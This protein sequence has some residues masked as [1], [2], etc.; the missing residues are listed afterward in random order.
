MLQATCQVKTKDDPP[1][2]RML[3]EP[4]P[5][6]IYLPLVEESGRIFP[7]A[8]P[9]STFNIQH[10]T[11]NIRHST[12]DIRYSI[13]PSFLHPTQKTPAAFATGVPI[14]WP[15]CSSLTAH[16]SPLTIHD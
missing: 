8:S 15:V 16:Y 10:S 4:A 12:F 9:T 3:R 5:P 13:V 14:N 1:T 2:G 11:F 7:T 6:L